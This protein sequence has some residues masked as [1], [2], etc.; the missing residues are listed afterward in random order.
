MTRS[1]VFLGMLIATISC[2]SCAQKA[3][4]AKIDPIQRAIDQNG[5]SLLSAPNI[6]SVSIGVLKDGRTYTGHFGVLD[7]GKGNR[8]TDSTIYEIASVSKSFTGTLVAQAVLENKMSLEDDIRKYLKGDFTNLEYEGYPIQVKHLVTHTA[9]LPRFLP[10]RMNDLFNTIDETL[11]F[12]MYDMEKAYS[13]VEFMA[14]LQSIAIGIQPGTNYSYSNADTEL[15][16]YILEEIYQMPFDQLLQKNICEVA[17]MR[18]TK[19]HLSTKEKGRLANG[20]GETN[21]LVPHFANTLWGA[22]GGMKSTIQD[23]LKYMQF[24]L[25]T[26]NKIVE[27][28]HTVLYS[29]DN[30]Q[31]GYLWPI[32]DD[33]EDGISYIIHGGAFGTQNY[34]LISPKHNLGISIITNQSGPETQ[35]RLWDALSS[36][37]ADITNNP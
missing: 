23:L 6:N 20:Y 13:K 19:V 31:I 4:E 25:D 10:V 21:K 18:T 36:L 30:M 35:G 29:T 26:T 17:K 15:L 5:D 11:P 7:K 24:N 9:G 34:L 8:P 2:S 16:A 33:A 37:M 1:A 28:A 27:E 22:G 12:R 32:Y 14:D 3:P